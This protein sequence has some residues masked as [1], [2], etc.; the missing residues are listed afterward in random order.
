MTTDQGQRTKRKYTVTDKVLAANR[1]NL[2]KAR[3][4]DKKIRYRATPKRLEGSRASLIKARQSPNYKPYVRY[5]LRAV[6]LRQSAL[7]VGETLED[8]DR[9]TQLVERVLPAN[10]QRLHNGVRGLAQ[11]LWRRRR[12]FGSRVH[13]ET[14][15]FYLELE[16]VGVWGLCPASVQTMSFAT[17]HLFMEGE[18]PRQETMM[19]CLDKRL[20]RVAEAYL[21][22]YTRDLVHLGVW[23]KHVFRADFLDQP[24]EVI[25]NGLLGRSKVK[26]RLQKGLGKA[27]KAAALFAW[28]LKVARL[29]KSGLLKAWVERGYPLPDPRREEDFA[30][31]L[32][33]MEAAFLGNKDAGFGLGMAEVGSGRSAPASDIG[34]PTSELDARVAKFK[35]RYPELYQAVR[36]LAE[37]TWQRLRVFVGQA[38]KEAKELRETLERAAAGT[39][40]PGKKSLKELWREARDRRL[41]QLPRDPIDEALWANYQEALEKAKAEK[42]KRQAGS[43]KQEDGAQKQKP[44]SAA[45]APPASEP[46][47]APNSES[48]IPDPGQEGQSPIDNHP[49]A[50]PSPSGAEPEPRAS[51][52]GQAPATSQSEAPNSEAEIPNPGQ[53]QPEQSS[54]GNHPSAIPSPSGAEPEPRASASGQAPAT[55]QSEAPKPEAEIPNPGQEQPEQSSIDN[56]Q[57][58]IPSPSGAEPEPRASASGQASATSQSEA[59]KPEPRNPNPGGSEQSSIDNHQSQ[60]PSPGPRIPNFRQQQLD[61]MRLQWRVERLIGVFLCSEAYPAFKAAAECNHRVEKAF[62]DLERALQDALPPVEDVGSQRS[63]VGSKP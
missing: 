10:R 33:L 56:H 26:R 9:H 54:T 11:A 43:K 46:S 23:G 3:A 6:D 53:E 45:G 58:A 31:H 18:H 63:A 13:R 47:P 38:E 4:V 48:R 55:S 35:A 39:L 2:E 61:G 14:L 12:L 36:T 52:S 57:S 40:G 32:G 24:P 19:E 8:Y 49:S 25:G 22:D 44:E 28:V 30:L 51:A 27:M 7:Q 50:I 62:Q 20:V 17:W 59:P 37:T 60:I 42:R 5:G 16:K 15:S 21:A 1:L 41:A 34:S 29:T